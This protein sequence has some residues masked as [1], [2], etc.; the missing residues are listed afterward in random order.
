MRDSTTR[1]TILIVAGLVATVIGAWSL[2]D[3]DAF[4]RANGIDLSGSISLLSEARAAGGGLMT[5]GILI[6][7]GAFIARLTFTAALVGAAVY[8]SYG[9]ARLL[10]LALDGRPAG[11]L[12]WATAAELLLGIACVFALVRY[13]GD[14]TQARRH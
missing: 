3:P 4:R 13:R 8:L 2:F 10:S 1:K 9:V 6:M 14:K 12:M 7:L 11:N 5:T